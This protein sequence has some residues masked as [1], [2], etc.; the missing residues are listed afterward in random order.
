LAILDINPLFLFRYDQ[1]FRKQYT[2]NETTYVCC[3]CYWNCSKG[4]SY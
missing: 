4:D 2:S 1:Y 3:K